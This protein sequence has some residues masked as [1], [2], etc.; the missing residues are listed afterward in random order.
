MLGQNRP[1]IRPKRL[2]FG[3]VVYWAL[4]IAL[5]FAEVQWHVLS[6]LTVWDIETL[7][8]LVPMTAEL[9]HRL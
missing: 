9:V 1:V 7:R 6:R 3:A 8:S 2:L 5:L 4:N